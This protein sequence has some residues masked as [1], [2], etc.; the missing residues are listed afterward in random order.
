MEAAQR[1]ALFAVGVNVPPD[2]FGRPIR[3]IVTKGDVSLTS[4]R[5]NLTE[6]EL[7]ALGDFNPTGTKM[8]MIVSKCDVVLYLTRKRDRAML[9]AG[10]QRIR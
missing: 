8:V 5:V 9:H 3:T 2:R 10:K 4:I 1:A 6:D 7:E